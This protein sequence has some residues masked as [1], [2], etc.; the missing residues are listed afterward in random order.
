MS[1]SC[2]LLLN[3]EWAFQDYPLHNVIDWHLLL[4][5]TYSNDVQQVQTKLKLINQ[6]VYFEAKSQHSITLGKCAKKS[7]SAGSFCSPIYRPWLNHQLKR[8][9]WR[10][11]TFQNIGSHQ[12]EYPS[13][14]PSFIY[15]FQWGWKNIK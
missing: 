8:D 2:K 4:N 13:S 12:T 14:K 7:L 15:S 5:K 6:F 10:S 3:L 11:L 9:I 1:I